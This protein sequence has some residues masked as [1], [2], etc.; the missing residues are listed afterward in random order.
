MLGDLEEWK[1]QFKDA[2][3]PPAQTSASCH[4]PSIPMIYSVSMIIDCESRRVCT[5][6][7]VCLSKEFSQYLY[8]MNFH[9]WG[10]YT[11]AYAP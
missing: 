2:F 10:T 7:K 9:Y 4:K 5:G 6:V 11:L 3:I 8:H 1:C